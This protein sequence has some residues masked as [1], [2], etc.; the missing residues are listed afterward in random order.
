MA[1]R[2]NVR[3]LK[4]K[5]RQ[6]Y[7]RKR[8]LY[9]Y[10]KIKY[11]W[12][13]WYRKGGLCSSRKWKRIHFT[14][15]QSAKLFHLF[16]NLNVTTVNSYVV[17]CTGEIPLIRVR[18]VW[19]TTWIGYEIFWKRET[20]NI[21]EKIQQTADRKLICKLR[22]Y[23]TSYKIRTLNFQQNRNLLKRKDQK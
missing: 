9:I 15:I 7:K 8:K 1:Q 22:G 21:I 23:K 20:E 11:V 4:K 17:K 19:K 10:M 6:I 2:I 16:T 13:L 18:G 14:F 5:E 3:Y 12:K